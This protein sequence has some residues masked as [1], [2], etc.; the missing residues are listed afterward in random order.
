[1]AVVAC[2]PSVAFVATVASVESVENVETLNQTKTN[3]PALEQL[4]GIY[5]FVFQRLTVHRRCLFSF[6]VSQ[7]KIHLSSFAKMHLWI[8]SYWKVDDFL[9]FH[10]FSGYTEENFLHKSAFFGLV[11][12]A[13]S[14]S[15]MSF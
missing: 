12:N 9:L 2:V 4:S 1:M 10:S 14:V 6:E 11:K 8:H 3:R 15:F 13:C 7:K 5:R